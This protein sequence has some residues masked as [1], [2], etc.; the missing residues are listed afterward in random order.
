MQAVAFTAAP[1][2]QD[3]HPPPRP[4]CD[5][6]PTA[7]LSRTEGVAFTAAPLR[8]LRDLRAML[9]PIRVFLAPEAAMSNNPPAR[10]RLIDYAGDKA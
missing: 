4:P 9:C 2:Q 1:D 8:D 3:L 7:P 10:P 5:A 6:L